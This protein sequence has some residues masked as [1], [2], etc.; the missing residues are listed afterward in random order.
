MTMT[1]SSFRLQE[2]R[3]QPFASP[4]LGTAGLCAAAA[5]G[6]Q[7][8][9]QSLDQ[10]AQP[11]C[12]WQAT[13]PVIVLVQMGLPGICLASP[14]GARR[15]GGKQSTC[16]SCCGLDAHLLAST[17]VCMLSAALLEV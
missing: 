12:R 10:P 15:S 2:N 9:Q 11:D 6:T 5:A 8:L 7:C 17:A 4:M 16:H 3:E 14:I 1:L 13:L